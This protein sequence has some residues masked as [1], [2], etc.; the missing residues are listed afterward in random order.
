[1]SVRRLGEAW[2]TILVEAAAIVRSYDTGVT[3][4]QLFYRL[5]SA[6]LLR[7]TRPEYN[8]LSTRTAEARR[9]GGFP[10]LVDRTRSIVVPTCWT[11]PA[12]ARRD[13]RSW[14]RPA[15]AAP[16]ETAAF[17]GRSR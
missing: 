4:R 1:V 15:S 3:L 6:G 16:R 10:D 11:S 17:A 8:Q 5:V 9:A 12:E 13:L 14:Y 7:N 2:D